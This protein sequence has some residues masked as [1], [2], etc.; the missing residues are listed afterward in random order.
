MCNKLNVKISPNGQLAK[1]GDGCTL[2]ASVGEIDQTFTR[3]K[4]SLCFR[5]IVVEKLNCDI[6]GGMTFLVRPKTGE[7]KIH[8]KFT[9]YQTNMLMQPPQ[10]KSVV[11]KSCTVTP[12]KQVL[13]PNLDPIW[14]KFPSSQFK[15]S[16]YD[17]SVLK[18]IL[19]PE[20]KTEKTVLIEPRE[21]NNN[22]EWPP[23]QLC[24]VDNQSISIQNT[25]NKVIKIPKD[26]N[27]LNIKPTEDVLVS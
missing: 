24:I 11:L 4:W 25:T 16:K 19:P 5:S 14:S 1:L 27:I 7:K 20:Y 26:V 23:V 18:V 8:K 13:F 12:P 21:Q 10:I 6:Y 22:T 17:G 2:L 9:I 3:D 15:D